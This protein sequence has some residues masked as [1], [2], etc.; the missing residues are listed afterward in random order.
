[1][2]N[3]KI[4]VVDDEQP[5]VHAI[6]R[7]ILLEDDR[8]EILSANNGKKGL[9]IFQKEKP[10]LVILDLKM[11]V[12]GGIEFLESVR[13]NPADPCA[14]IV[15]TGY[16]SDSDIKKCFELGISAFLR[17]PFNKYEFIGLVRHVITFKR[18]QQTLKHEFIHRKHV[19]EPVFHEKAKYSSLFLSDLK[20]S[21]LPIVEHSKGLSDSSISA[22]EE[23]IDR[24][25]IIRNKSE[26][27]LDII[28]K[29]CTVNKNCFTRGPF[30][31]ENIDVSCI[32]TSVA[33]H[34]LHE[35]G[36]RGIKVRINNQTANCWN[37]LE[38]APIKADYYQIK[39]LIENLL[40]NA[41]KHARETIS[42]DLTSGD[43]GV[44][45]SI[46]ND[47]SFIQGQYLE[48]IFDEYFQAPGSNSG[49]GMGLYL[50][51]LIVENHEGRIN[52]ISSPETGTCLIIDL[53]S[54][55]PSP[56]NAVQAPSTR[57][58]VA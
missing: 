55:Q 20:N 14:V 49:T 44:R 9:E 32:L 57:I 42:I 54:G 41:V 45:L 28:E 19:Q 43:S 11:P 7:T 5:V 13:L 15:L 2:L 36:C 33:G 6:Y 52:V 35:A 10:V 18:I 39:T 21:L 31:P 16:S 22:T 56:Q 30:S 38:K 29:A 26:E 51:K 12:M 23:D 48:R 17:K 4:L 50:T 46:T 25:Q 58:P 37:T 27:L 53:P 8:Y 40:D 47:G 34:Y 24:L 3:N 1:M